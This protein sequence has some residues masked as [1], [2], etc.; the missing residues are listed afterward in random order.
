MNL[1]F[2]LAQQSDLPAYTDLLQRTYQHSLINEAIGLTKACFS[3]EVFATKDTQT[4]LR[5]KLVISGDQQTWLAFDEDQLVGTTTMTRKSDSFEF[6]GM[7]VH[8]EYQ[9]RGIASQLFAKVQVFSDKAPL[10]L[11][12]FAHNHK[13]IAIY[14]KWGFTIDRTREARK[15]HWPEW[16]EG[17]EVDRVYM[18]HLR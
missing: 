2:R 5:K 11:E 7:Y 13:A 9:N 3:K 1:T 12:L 4:Y 17:I 18:H 8:P 15:M 16:P 14:K 6:N 10:T